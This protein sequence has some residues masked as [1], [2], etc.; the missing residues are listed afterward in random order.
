M[1]EVFLNDRKIL[2]SPKPPETLFD[3]HKPVSFDK[4]YYLALF[5]NFIYGRDLVCHVVCDSVK[6]EF[7][8]FRSIFVNIFAAGGVVVKDNRCLFI[9]KNGK[10]D[11]PK[12]KIEHG[13][14]AETAA[15]REVEEECGITGHTVVAKLPQT[16]HLY[17]SEYGKSRGQWVFKETFWFEMKYTGNEAGMPDSSEGIEKIEWISKADA[18]MVLENTYESLKQIIRPYFF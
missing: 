2:F 16:Y 5:Q 17:Q 15:L 10:W 9:F 8:V 1:Y 11:L 12:G 3:L 4:E 7:Q 6:A 13:E 18:V 14:N